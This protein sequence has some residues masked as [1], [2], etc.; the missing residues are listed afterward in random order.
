MKTPSVNCIQSNDND[1][2]QQYV[3][4]LSNIVHLS[5]VT[6]INFETNVGISESADIKFILQ[7]CPNVIDL[8]ISPFYLYLASIIDN[9]CLNRIFKQIKILNLIRGY[10]NVPP[11]SVSNLVQRFPSLTDIEVHVALFTFFASVIDALLSHLRNLSYVNISYSTPLI[12]NQPFSR[13]D[14]IDKRR[15][16]FGFNIIDEHNVTV[17]KNEG[18]IEIRLS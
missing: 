12:F 11:N 9:Q 14:I 18:S 7:A 15:Q 6:K 10:Y 16:A 4:Y 3:A 2:A 5:N 1:D 8:K 17:S 13:S